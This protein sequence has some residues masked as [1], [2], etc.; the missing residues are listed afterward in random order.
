MG[1]GRGT[2]NGNKPPGNFPGRTQ[3]K[4][5][6]AM[7]N[8]WATEAE[9]NQ[10]SSTSRTITESPKRGRKSFS[11]SSDNSPTSKSQKPNNDDEKLFQQ[12]RASL[13]PTFSSTET[14][15]N[16]ENRHRPISPLSPS[17]QSSHS[18][19]DADDHRATDRNGDGDIDVNITTIQGQDF[20]KIS[21]IRVSRALRNLVS[22]Y[23]FKLISST[24]IKVTINVNLLPNLIGRKS[25]CGKD[26]EVS[27]VK[28]SGPREYSWGKFYSQSL[29]Y[30]SDQE[31][32]EELDIENPNILFV[33]RLYRGSDKIP[34]RLVK[35]K[36]QGNHRP[37]YIYCLG[38]AYEVT[39]YFP[40][41]KRCFLCHSYSHFT[42]DCKTTARCR[43]C[44][45]VH[46]DSNPCTNEKNCAHCG[47]GH[48]TD[49]QNCPKF[50]KEKEVIAISHEKN[51]P[52]A[53]ARNQ[54]ASGEISYASKLK[55]KTEKL[56][57]KNSNLGQ[58]STDSNTGQTLKTSAGTG[59]TSIIETKDVETGRADINIC[60]ETEIKETLEK[61]DNEQTERIIYSKPIINQISTWKGIVQKLT[62]AL[63]NAKDLQ[64]MKD[65]FSIIVEELEADLDLETQN[66]LDKETRNLI[67]PIN[68]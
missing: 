15:P 34:T 35:V 30:S 44:N 6:A 21:A 64:D 29:F 57:S 26:V 55:I 53:I 19:D 49:D 9:Q 1:R 3:S 39:E 4:G 67:S 23:N 20:G 37:E 63:T 60:M 13:R 2:Q 66:L 12:V 8:Q 11:G 38:A 22:V 40:P 52:Y 65:C 68:T 50:V 33:K 59:T 27:V 42:S 28:T 45:D 5:Q 58:S 18:M 43:V 54:V 62:M 47:P 61:P 25:F 32:F 24:T 10:P 56:K 46:T 41:V 31:I 14:S 51:I 36:F 48:T 7:V 16:H 17:Q